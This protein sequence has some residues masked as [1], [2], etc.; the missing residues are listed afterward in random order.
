M[1]SMEYWVWLSSAPEVSFRSKASI[2][3]QYGDAEAAY[4]APL[5]A[6][7]RVEGV[8]P[9]DAAL[10]EKRDLSGVD[11][12]LTQ[13][14]QQGITLIPFMD[15][16]Y[17]R[18]LKSIYSPPPL[19]YVRGELPRVDRLAAIAV[20][21]TRKASPYGCRMSR[22]LAYEITKCGGLVVSGLTRGIDAAAAQAALDAGGSCIGVLGVPHELEKSELAQKVLEHGALITEYPPGTQPYRSFFRERN[23]ITSGL[24][25]GVVAVEAPEESGTHLFV[26]EAAEQG[27]EIFAVPGNAD[28]QNSVGTNRIIQEGAKPV[29]CGWDVMCEFELR[30]PAKKRSC[31]VPP[32]KGEAPAR[33]R[34]ST[35]APAAPRQKSV[36]KEENTGYIDLRELAGTLPPDQQKILGAIRAPSVSADEIA[37][38]T[39]L[40]VSR[41]LA[42]LTVLEIKGLVRSLPGRCV[43]L[44]IQKK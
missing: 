33:Q 5:G 27:R 6:Y 13:C 11:R 15:T 3:A 29:T 41:V 42:Q 21:G 2:I 39:G 10:L 7:S 9:K 18:R 36:D 14:E 23:R 17:P 43:A 34:R 25:V 12:I 38:A 16:R 30:Y 28:S 22:K 24:S 8:S 20:V 35:Q 40:A 37:E 32:P 1:P 26:A 44:N 31:T 19:L 4:Y